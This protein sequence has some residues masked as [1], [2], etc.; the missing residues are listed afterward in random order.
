[1][2][3]EMRVR[4]FEKDEG[5]PQRRESLQLGGDA[6]DVSTGE[7]QES[8]GHRDAEGDE[9]HR[10]HEHRHVCLATSGGD[11]SAIPKHTTYAA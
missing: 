4:V 3:G 1:M 11:A 9:E 6:I 7:E 2:S 10:H 8:R 5:V